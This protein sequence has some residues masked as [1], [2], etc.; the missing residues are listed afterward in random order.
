MLSKFRNKS[1]IVSTDSIK[2]ADIEPL[3]QEYLVDNVI[4]AIEKI[5]KA[6]YKKAIVI[7][8]F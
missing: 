2:V 7:Q 6:I 1:T 4:E 3:Q 5:S 8:Y